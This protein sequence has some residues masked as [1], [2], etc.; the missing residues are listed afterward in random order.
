MIWVL[1]WGYR[2]NEN[3]QSHLFKSTLPLWCIFIG[4]N[5]D[6]IALPCLWVTLSLLVLTFDQIIWFVKVVTLI[7]LSCYMDL[8]KLIH[9]F[10]YVD[11]GDG[12]DGGG[13]VNQGEVSTII[14]GM[15]ES[16]GFRKYSTLLVIQLFSRRLCLCHCLCICLCLC[17]CVPNSF[18]NSY[19][20]KLSENVWV[21]GSGASRSEIWSDITMAGRTN[22]RWTRK[23]RA[24][25]PMDHG[26]LSK[27]LS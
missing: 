21:W 20:Q 2:R 5:L 18:L 4:P 16:S 7:S 22:K 13:E 10:L 25:Q 9:G 19:Y 8:S 15:L 12:G 26:R 1:A 24:N 27:Y 23:D 3:A 14:L 17:I 11:G 6:H